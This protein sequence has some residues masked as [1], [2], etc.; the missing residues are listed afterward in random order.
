MFKS[1]MLKVRSR[2]NVEPETL[3][4]L[5]RASFLQAR[6]LIDTVS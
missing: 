1:S 3:N 5:S 2:L 4:H 6:P